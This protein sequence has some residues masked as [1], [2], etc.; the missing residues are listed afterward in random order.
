ME[1]VRDGN[2]EHDQLVRRYV[3][4]YANFSRKLASEVLARTADKLGAL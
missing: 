4:V 1:D 2:R 3:N